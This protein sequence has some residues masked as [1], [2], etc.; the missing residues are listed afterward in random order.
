VILSAKFVDSAWITVLV[1]PLVTAMLKAIKRHY[2]LIDRQLRDE[3]PI[4][5][6]G[7]EPPIVLLPLERWDRLAEKAVRFAL[8][9]SHDVVAIHL[10]QLEG[11]NAEEH[12]ARNAGFAPPK[13]VISPS[14]YRSFVG[15]LLKHVAEMETQHP[16]RS[17]AVVVPEVVEEH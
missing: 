7:L 2:E 6:S 3:G 15:R 5:L 13:L 16:D 12:E 4:Y 11:P 14:P 8:L 10:T 9:L 1:I 17:L